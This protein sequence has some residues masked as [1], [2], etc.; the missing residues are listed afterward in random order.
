MLSIHYDPFVHDAFEHFFKPLFSGVATSARRVRS[1]SAP[2]VELTAIETGWA[3]LAE[4][5]GVAPE[6]VELEVSEHEIKLSYALAGQAPEGMSRVGGDRAR[7]TVQRHW[8][9]RRAIDV[10]AVEVEFDKGRLNVK[11]NTRGST[12]PR[13][14]AIKGT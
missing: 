4:L 1:V 11:L 5:P 14:I 3:L 7:G 13:K 6:D 9:V 2:K 10:N 8:R 12:G